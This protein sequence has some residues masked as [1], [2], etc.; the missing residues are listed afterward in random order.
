MKNEIRELDNRFF[1]RLYL[2]LLHGLIAVLEPFPKLQFCRSPI[3]FANIW[4]YLRLI[5]VRYLYYSSLF[6]S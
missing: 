2:S 5:Y 6:H 1:T 3:A 4:S